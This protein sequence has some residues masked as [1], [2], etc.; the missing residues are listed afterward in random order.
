MLLSWQLFGQ[1]LLIANKTNHALKIKY[2]QLY[3][4]EK[5]APYVLQPKVKVLP[6]KTVLLGNTKTTMIND[7][8]VVRNTALE[9]KPVVDFNYL[10]KA[11]KQARNYRKVAITLEFTLDPK[12]NKIYANTIEQES[13]IGPD[14]QLEQSRTVHSHIRKS[15]N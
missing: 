14:T 12:S 4:P 7:V 2:S 5:W 6:G 9:R 13:I 11:L 15:K 1:D 8:K 3:E 10:S